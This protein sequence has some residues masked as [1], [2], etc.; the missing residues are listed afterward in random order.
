MIGPSNAPAA[1]TAPGEPFAVT[2][3]AHRGNEGLARCDGVGD[4]RSRNTREHEVRD[5]R[6][7]TEAALPVPHE[8]LRPR[9]EA[10]GQPAAI[11]ELPCKDEQGNLDE[12]VVV[13]VR[14][15]R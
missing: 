3:L 4:R 13:D 1:I 9:N 8:R 14:D 5:D 6:N 7:V 15:H 11:H 10:Q 2:F 12:R